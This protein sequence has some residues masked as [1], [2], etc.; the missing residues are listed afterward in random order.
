MVAAFLISSE[1]LLD[2][3]K[4]QS[5]SLNTAL[6]LSVPTFFMISLD[7]GSNI[8][9]QEKSGPT[10]ESN[11][12]LKCNLNPIKGTYKIIFQQKFESKKIVFDLACL[13]WT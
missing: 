7:N 6:C 1:D 4:L 12:I 5:N 10:L 3:S 11:S 9:Q 8:S 2:I 13:K